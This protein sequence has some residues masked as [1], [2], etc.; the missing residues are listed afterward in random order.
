MADYH[1]IPCSCVKSVKRIH[2]QRETSGKD[3]SGAI[4]FL[5]KIVLYFEHS[6]L[7]QT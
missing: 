5:R 4:C 1:L 7:Q 6:P 2:K 3:Q